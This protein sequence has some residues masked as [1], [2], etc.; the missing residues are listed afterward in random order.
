MSLFGR[1]TTSKNCNQE[2][3]R[4]C[5]IDLWRSRCFCSRHLLNSVI[6]ST[7]ETLSK[8]LLPA[9]PSFMRPVPYNVFPYE[10]DER[11]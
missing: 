3:R 5:I 2:A 6:A 4:T 8:G 11:E 9:V 1:S 7:K 10:G